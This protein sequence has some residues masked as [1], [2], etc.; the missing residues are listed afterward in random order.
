MFRIDF[1]MLK[2]IF[3]CCLSATTRVL[4]VILEYFAYFGTLNFWKTQEHSSI[5]IEHSSILGNFRSVINIKNTRVFKENTRVFWWIFKVF[6]ENWMNTRVVF[7]SLEYLLRTKEHSSIGGFTRVFWGW[8]R[9]MIFILTY[10]MR[11]RLK[12]NYTH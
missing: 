1:G 8:D 12:T 3:K 9:K 10:L 6:M 5:H 2:P 11:Y 7:R 4:W